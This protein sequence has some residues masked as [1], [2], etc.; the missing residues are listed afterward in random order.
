MQEQLLTFFPWLT[1]P[2]ADEKFNHLIADL[3]SVPT[4]NQLARIEHSMLHKIVA[5]Y[6]PENSHPENEWLNHLMAAIT[7]SSRQA[8][9]IQLRAEGLARQCDEFTNVEYDFLYDKTQHLLTIGYNADEHRADNS[10]YDLLASEARLTT[11][12]A[13]AQGKLPQQSWFAL[14]R[15]LTNIGTDPILLSWS[16]SMF[17]YLMPLLV[18]PTYENTLLD[19][20][21][22]SVIK[23]QMEY[24]SSRNIPWGISE[25]GYSNVD[26][27]LNY[28]YRAFGVPGLGFKRGLG[29]DLVIAPYATIMGLMVAPGDAYNNLQVM[30]GNGLKGAMDFMKQSI[31]QLHVCRDARPI[32]LYVLSWRITRVW[33]FF[34]SV[35]YCWISRC[36]NA[37]KRMCRLNLPYSYCRKEFPVSLLFIHQRC[38]N[39]TLV[40]RRAAMN[41]CG[42]ST[43]RI[44]LYLRC[45]CFPTDDIM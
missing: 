8:K 14:G 26:A 44:L 15:Q 37:S 28:Q 35:I 39:L 16:G 43:R 30:K 41:P 33:L 31:I 1:L 6:L 22:K 25:S 38:M 36:R 40:F 12:V 2:P 45:S 11:F 5:C 10:F 19:E 4:I 24:C 42:S 20:T 18:M 9:H 13:V 34:P 17:E 23:K 3:P 21:N 27:H 32:A 29:S 7:E